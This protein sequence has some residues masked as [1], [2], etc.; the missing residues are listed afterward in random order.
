M[1]LPLNLVTYKYYE[2]NDKSSVL[3]LNS[4]IMSMEVLRGAK[5]GLFC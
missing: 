2:V 1:R 5:N 4:L 3:I